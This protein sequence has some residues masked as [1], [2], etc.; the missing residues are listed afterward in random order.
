MSDLGIKVSKDGDSAYNQSVKLLAFHSDYPVLKAFKIGNA[1]ITCN[2]LG[3]GSTTIAH[4]LSYPPAFQVFAKATARD[5]FDSGSSTYANAFFPT[6]HFN[7]WYEHK[8]LEFISVTADS[9]NLQINTIGNVAAFAN[10][11]LNFRYYLFVDLSETF[12]GADTTPT[13]TY[14][15]KVSQVG[16]DV[17]STKEYKLSASSAYKTLQFHDVHKYENKEITLPKMFA[18][19][20]DTDTEEGTYVDYN[21][22]LGYQPFFVAYFESSRLGSTLLY[23]APHTEYATSPYGPV[24]GLWSVTG[25]ADATKIRLSFYRRSIYDTSTSSVL[26]NW[27]SSEDITLKLLVFT[28]NL[29]GSTYG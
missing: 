15:F 3:S 11:T 23:E 26:G 2:S 21:H 7:D 12:T 10:K 13:D 4:G 8:Y 1:S 28:E 6:G 20:Y 25:F 27:T 5:W 9:T 16:E 18:T 17:K 24:A 29:A 19:R 22:G 14:G